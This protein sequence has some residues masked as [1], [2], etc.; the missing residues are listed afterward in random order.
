M[1]I[2]PTEAKKLP[3]TS[4]ISDLEAEIDDYLSSEFQRGNRRPFY[5]TRDMLPGE[6]AAI[7]ATY[8]QAGWRVTEGSDRDGPHLI[9]EE[10]TL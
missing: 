5:D 7:V 3:T 9:F 8:R 10:S 6:I 4:R 2:T 1:P